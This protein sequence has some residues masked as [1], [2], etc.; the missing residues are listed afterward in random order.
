METVTPPVHILVVD[1]E[2]EAVQLLE[3]V[4][5]SH[6][7]RVSKAASGEEALATLQ[8]A[9]QTEAP[10]QLMLLDLMLPEMDG[11]QVLQRMRAQPRLARLPV[12]IVTG[13]YS[14][15]QEI[16]GLEAGADDVI[17]KPFSTP[18]LLARVRTLLRARHAEEALG[19]AEALSHLLIEGMRDM[20]F[21]ADERGR[22]TY[23]SPSAEALTGYA[24]A[25]MTSGQIT[26]EWLIH[27]A[28]HER[29]REQ[30]QA[31]LEGQGAEIE[32]RIIRKDGTLLWAAISVEPLRDAAGLQGILRDV[33]ARHQTEEALRVRGAELAALNLLARRISE[34]LDPQAML[35]GNAETLI[36]GQCRVRLVHT[37]SDHQP[38]VRAWHGLTAATVAEA[39]SIKSRNTST[40]LRCRSSRSSAR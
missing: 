31:A 5:R 11:L 30:M 28:D 32:S 36:D 8:A 20:V 16:A 35:S 15:G 4:L 26:L 10:V 13:A 2:P 1:D 18:Q 3:F 40:W 23:V 27:P 14:P 6:G 29:V 33:T 7:Y 9:S 37:L 39:D 19:R 34:S 17:A 38:R 24:Q 12:I 21:I 25:E 22:F